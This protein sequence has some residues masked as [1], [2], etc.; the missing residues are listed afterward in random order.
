MTADPAGLTEVWAHG[1]RL[2][3]AANDATAWAAVDWDAC[4]HNALVDAT[5]APR[6]RARSWVTTPPKVGR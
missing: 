4:A 6:N 5:P 2:D 1:R 3:A